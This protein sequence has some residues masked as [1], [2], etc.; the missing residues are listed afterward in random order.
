MMI[1][2]REDDASK[3][4]RDTV[5]EIEAYCAAALLFS[6]CVRGGKLRCNSFIRRAH[7]WRHAVRI[8]RSSWSL[9]RRHP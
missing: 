8:F 5:K 4:S 3:K 2:A 1:R 7:V 9:W 6:L